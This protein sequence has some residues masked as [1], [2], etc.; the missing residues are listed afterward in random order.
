MTFCAGVHL[1]STR[2]VRCNAARLAKMTPD[3]VGWWHRR[4]HYSQNEFEAY[5]H[6]WATSAVRHSAGEWLTAPQGAAVVEMVAAIRLAAG[7]VKRR[8]FSA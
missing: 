6:V 5:M 3:A 7:L 2:C 4:G 1:I 8:N